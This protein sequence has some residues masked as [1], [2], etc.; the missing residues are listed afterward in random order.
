MPWYENES[1]VRL[2]YEEQGAGPALVLLHGWCMS[3]VVWRFQLEQLSGTFRVIAPDLRGHGR[4]ERSGDGYSFEGFAADI[5]ALFRR[6]DLRGALLAGW[7]LGAQ[8]AL[9]ASPILRERLAGLVLI[10]GTPRFTATDDFPH[11]LAETEASGMGLKVR[12]NIGKALEGFTKR[13]FTAGE[14]DDEALA[15]RIKALLATVPL[16]DPEMAMA[17]LRA[18]ATA[19]MRNLLSEVDLP[20]LI[21]NGDRDR[22]CLPE[23][24]EYMARRIESSCH[25]VL[26]GCGHAPFLTRYDEFD[27]FIVNFSRRTFEQAG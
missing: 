26:N 23:A 11:A 10:S 25:V 8:V 1:G 22:I 5:A 3:S 15:D 16:P 21:I 4:S 24:S 2:W 13:M 9:L 7:S 14:L 18:L 20:T 27:E 12:R 17:S 19:D 6:L